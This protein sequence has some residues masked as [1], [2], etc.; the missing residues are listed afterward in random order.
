MRNKIRQQIL[1]NVPALSEV[2]QPGM[3][4]KGVQKPYAVV[5]FSGEIEG[6]IR[7]SY[8][9]DIEVWVYTDRANYSQADTLLEDIIECLTT[10][11]IETE[12]GYQFKLECTSL[13]EDLPFD[14][15]LEAIPKYATFVYPLLRR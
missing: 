11:F 1:S 6:N 15:D 2:F 10:D 8:E 3:A 9:R 7:K 14:I 4:E 12:D 5:K 13:S